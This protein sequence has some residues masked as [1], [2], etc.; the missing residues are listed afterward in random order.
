MLMDGQKKNIVKLTVSKS[1]TKINI[2]PI[3][4]LMAFFIELEENN[5]KFLLP[6]RFPNSQTN[7]W[8]KSNVYHNV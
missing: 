4:I 2:L 7:L 6:H 1:N 3:I 5:P 8:R